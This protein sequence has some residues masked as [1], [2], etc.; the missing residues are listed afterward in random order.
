MYGAAAPGR[1]RRPS[2]DDDVRSPE[3]KHLVNGVEA[4]EVD[5]SEMKSPFQWGVYSLAILIRLA[6]RVLIIS[7]IVSIG[8]FSLW[9]S[10]VAGGTGVAL[11]FFGAGLERLVITKR[12]SYS[13]DLL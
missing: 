13:S 1:V 7:A 2:D 12:Q 8:F 9:K 3:T 10:L 11:F 4:L 5:D 6:G